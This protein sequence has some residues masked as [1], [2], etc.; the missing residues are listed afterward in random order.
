MS[1]HFILAVTDFSKLGDSA[2]S[3]AAHLSAEH[4]AALKLVCFAAPGEDHPR[5]AACRLD[6]LAG[7]L[8]RH[9]GIEVQ[10]SNRIS[11]A[12]EDLLADAQL[13]D[14]VVWGVAP[15][16]TMRSFLVGQ[17]VDGLLR[18]LQRP[19]LVVRSPAEG[20]YSSVLVSVDF[21][22][23]STDLVGLAFDISETARV[24]LFHA[25]GTPY[26]GKLR[27]AAVSEEVIKG[28]REACRRQAGQRMFQLTDFFDARRN[29]V[30]ATLG[31]GEPAR[32]VAVQQQR[33]GAE[34]I[35]VGKQP[36]SLLSDLWFQ[37]VAKRL[38]CLSDVD[39]LIAPHGFEPATS[40]VAVKR[41]ETVSATHRVRAGT[42]EAPQ[43][44]NPAAVL[45]R[46]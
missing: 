43:L 6:E 31:R 34:L 37:S 45:S 23:S 26:E 2:L 3:R 24:E 41:L 4:G 36:A 12:P 19:V 29:R 33:S 25:V 13:A 32:Q 42:P 11:L 44:P 9:H 18:K 28:Y 22:K 46:A 27:Y 40:Q 39:V 16:R 20:P 21:S 30:R 17:P 5:N 15:E 38:L 1:F 14:L 8:S 35:V 10:A 7:Q